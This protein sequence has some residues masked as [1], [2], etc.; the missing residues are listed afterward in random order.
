[1]ETNR[2]PIFACIDGSAQQD[3]IVD[4][5]SWISHRS[6]TPLKF[7]HNLEARQTA[8]SD[9]SGNLGP[10]AREE[11]LAE[12]VELE[13]QRSKILLEQGKEM[14]ESAC[15]RARQNGAVDITRQQRH[16]SLIESLIEL[17]LEI[18]LLVIGL[19]GESRQEKQQKLGS[20]IRTVIRSLHKPILVINKA[21]PQQEPQR[22]MFAY[23]SSDASRNALDMITGTP[24]F[25][26]LECH[27][28]HVAKEKETPDLQQTA[29]R[30]EHAGFKVTTIS[31]HGD[32]EAR[33][34]EYQKQNAIDITIMGA[35]GHSRI[36]E[37]LFGNVIHRLLLE[38]DTPVLLLR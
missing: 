26:G 35:F 6:N 4:Y 2:N 13:N 37:L 10:G 19:R 1:M 12:L 23:D 14:L 24:V 27:L 20:H 8:H 34:L 30:L 21:F 29:A 18:G 3:A 11:L 31:L 33:I 17:E 25:A 36:R 38:S 16:G 15:Q 28:V 5:A 22:C 9:L 32:V 7:I